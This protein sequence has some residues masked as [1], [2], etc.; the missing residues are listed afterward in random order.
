[1][2]LIIQ[3]EAVGVGIQGNKYH[4]TGVELFV[5]N[6]AKYYRGQLTNY[7]QVHQMLRC[8]DLGLKPVSVLYP[9]VLLAP[10]I[11]KMVNIAKGTSKEAD[12]PREGIVVRNYE[13]NVSFKV[14]NPQFL[15][16]YDS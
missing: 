12:I 7:D 4:K 16:K 14:I 2:G 3:G 5:F 11:P 10:T 1:M 15:L 6:I 13:N 8:I 9:S